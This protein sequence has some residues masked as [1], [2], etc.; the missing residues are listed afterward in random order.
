MAKRRAQPSTAESFGQ[1]LARIRK[2]RGFTQT[3]LGDTRWIVATCM[4]GSI[5]V[6]PSSL[7]MRAGDRHHETASCLS[8]FL[9]RK[10]SSNFLMTILSSSGK[11]S[12][13]WN[14]RKRSR[15]SNRAVA[16]WRSLARPQSPDAWQDRPLAVPRRSCPR[17]L[18]G[19]CTPI[20]ATVR[21][22]HPACSCLGAKRFAHFRQSQRFV[23]FAIGEQSRIA[24]DGRAVEL[25]LE[26]TVEFDP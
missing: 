13:S 19:D 20:A 3:E 17:S 16:A 15:S 1:R 12:T 8:L 24:R 4:A 11:R 14:W 21:P 7:R 9:M 5:R 6:N 18:P 22:I 23:E 2:D 10:A 25:Q 26:P